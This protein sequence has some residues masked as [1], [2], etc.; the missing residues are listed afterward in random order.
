MNFARVY[1]A[2]TKG[3]R[4]LRGLL[5]K[6][7][8]WWCGGQAGRRLE[9]ERGVL[10]RWRPHRNIQIADD[11]YLGQGVILDVPYPA[12][13]VVG[14]RAKI[15][16]YSLVAASN[17]VII[18]ADVQ[19]AES[20]SIR[21]SD[22]DVSIDAVM[23]T[24]P[25]RADAVRIGRGAWVARGVAVLRGSQIGEGAVIGAN[26]VVRGTIEPNAIA[27]GAPARVVKFR[28]E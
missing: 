6:V 27:V 21:D 16:H 7:R 24:A 17:A 1:A 25:L 12:R 2:R 18:E 26:A 3:A 5:F 11:V 8:V 15:M 28:G 10:I 9:I 20:S 13:L 4:R 19:I 23:A 22:H 14:D